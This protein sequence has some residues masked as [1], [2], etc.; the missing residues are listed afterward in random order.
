MEGG[1]QQANGNSAPIHSLEDPLKVGALEGEELG[2]RLLPLFDCLCHDHLAHCHQPLVRR[3]EHVLSAHKPDAFCAIPP[4][5]CRIFRRV[6]VGEDFDVTPLIDPPHE[7]TQIARNG[8]GSKR[9]PALDD[10]SRVTVEREPVTRLVRLPAKLH[11]LGPVVDTQLLAA[12]HA[13][14]APAAGHHGCVRGHAPPVGEDAFGGVHPAHVLGAGLRT[15]KDRGAALCFEGL[16]LLGSEDNLSNSSAGGGGES[17]ADHTIL[18]GGLRRKLGV[19]ELVEV[20]RVHLVDGL[21]LCDETLLV[22]VYGDLDGRGAGPLAVAALEHEELAVLDGELDVLHILIV[23]LKL[24]HVLKKLLVSVRHDLLQGADRVRGADTS[25]N[26]FALRVDQVLSIQLVLT[27]RRVAREQDPRAARRP[28]VAKHHALHRHGSAE[29]TLDAIDATVR[30][31][32]GRVPRGKDGVDSPHELVL[33]LGGEG[34]AFLLVHVLVRRDELLEVCGRQL[35]VVV[36]TLL[37]LELLESL[38]KKRV[39]HAHDHVAVHVQQPAVA[40]VGETLVGD[41]GK[42]LNHFVVEAK[43]EHCVH[44]AGHRHG[45]ARAHRHE[46][47]R[48]GVAHLHF[49]VSFD[50]FEGGRDLL[51][52]P[53]GELVAASDVLGAHLGGDGEARGHGEAE[54]GHFGKVGALAAEEGLHGGV[55]V[56]ALLGE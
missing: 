19:E 23:T 18:V 26:I 52:R 4:R 25:H 1:V 2:E 10:L 31:R 49:H 37:L 35:V 29:Q 11:G 54:L 55:A 28:Q 7:G 8:R 33:G 22:H 41:L 48:G 14:L 9:L 17:L 51:P 34:F 43:I 15:Y 50:L 5:L 47:G 21:V 45:G 12:R 53:R 30:H 38:L 32:T 40:V 46:E 39:M 3:E 6:S 16:S 56:A 27:R 36:H 20:R 42:A 44:H 24:L 13:S